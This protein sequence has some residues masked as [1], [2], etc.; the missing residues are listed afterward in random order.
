MLTTDTKAHWK[1]RALR[2]EAEVQTLRNIRAVDNS[3]E[4][5]LI[6]ENADMRVL[7]GEIRDAL[8]YFDRVKEMEAKRC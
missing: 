7:V 4:R 2:A 8:A 5:R 1:R 3:V 6:V